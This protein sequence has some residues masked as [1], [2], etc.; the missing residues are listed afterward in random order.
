[1]V[2][3]LGLSSGKLANGEEKHSMNITIANILPDNDPR[4]TPGLEIITG[5]QIL[6][7]DVDNQLISV[8]VEQ[9]DIEDN[10]G[11]AIDYDHDGDLDVYTAH[12]NSV[13]VWEGQTDEILLSVSVADRI[14]TLPTICNLDEDDALESAICVGNENFQPGKVMAFDNDLS[15]MWQ[16]P[17]EVFSNCLPISFDFDDNGINEVIHRSDDNLR[18]LNGMTGEE[19]FIDICHAG[20]RMEY[21]IIADV[22]GDGHAEL[23]TAC[24]ADPNSTSFR[25]HLRMY[26]GDATEWAL[27]RPVWNA[28]SFYNTQIEDDLSLPLRLQAAHLPSLSPKVHT[29]LNAITISEEDHHYD[30]SIENI[31]I[32]R[33][34]DS[35]MPVT[36]EI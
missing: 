2:N 29:Y 12:N 1:M 20:T 35:S 7:V 15:V 17:I 16:T 14:L 9:Q 26:E 32:S 8:A 3:I 22:D 31:T 21:P 28:L 36:I 24:N 23:I 25:G 11:V 34:C 5:N 10:F 27:T 13:I 33:D 4:Y 19:L 18:I 30:L 6:D